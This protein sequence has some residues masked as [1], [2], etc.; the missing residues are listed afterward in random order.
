MKAANG[1]EGSRPDY[2]KPTSRPELDGVY[3]NPSLGRAKSV[4]TAA[5]RSNSNR[6]SA[7]CYRPFH[8]AYATRFFFGVFRLSLRAAVRSITLVDGAALAGALIFWPFAFASITFL[9]SSA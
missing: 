9:T 3:S 6:L 5:S 2:A 7:I 8:G 1:G 4:A